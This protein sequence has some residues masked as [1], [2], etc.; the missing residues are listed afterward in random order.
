MEVD[1]KVDATE[2]EEVTEQEAKQELDRLLSDPQF[3]STDRNRN[4]LRFVASEMFEG[5][6]AAVKAYTIAVDVFGRPCSFDPTT[7]P[8]VRIE[9]TRLRA[10]LAQYY[11]A[12][13]EEGSVRIEL[14]RGRYIPV[15]TKA[16]PQTETLDEAELLDT[17]ET[18]SADS[19]WTS[20]T[21]NRRLILAGLAAAACGFLWYLSGTGPVFSDKPNVAIEMKLAG[22]KTDIEAGLIRDYLMTALSQYQTLKLAAGDKPSEA[23]GIRSAAGSLFGYESR[24]D[25]RYQVILKYHPGDHDRAVWWQVVNPATGEALRSGVERVDVDRR[26]G[27]D[28]RRE[29]ITDLANRFAGTR[30]VINSLELTRELASPTFGNGCVLRSAVA[31][32]QVDTSLLQEVQTCLVASLLNAPNDP[33]I[34]AELAIVNLELDAPEAPTELTAQALTLADKAVSLAP[35][36]DRAGY[37]QMLA[38]F[39]NDLREA[40]FV[41]GYRAMGLNPGNSLIPAELGAMLFAAGRW[42]EGAGMAIKA[43]MI[44]GVPPGDAEL[45][46]ALDA[47]RRGEFAEALL[48]VQ[49]MGRS[50]NYIANVLE[51]AA[52]GQMNNAAEID[53]AA[54]RLNA[55]RKHFP[56]S[57]RSDMAARHYSPEIVDQLGA[58]LTK[59]GFVL[60]APVADASN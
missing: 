55:K 24:V 13:A 23:G 38:Q 11:E 6:A 26:P 4:F 25:S 51:L 31:L 44:D 48:R 43:E 17:S 33:D 58:G 60:P 7:D 57:F 2:A 19:G 30:G 50:E 56:A 22:D 8:I 37:A 27:I 53:E 42:A 40:A 47:Y 18:G 54:K 32:E 1:V 29:L 36:S 28:V 49:Q 46:L 10:S 52:A 15:F 35:M 20:M 21:F 14:P 9:A 41:S 3:H 45:T 16:P 12:H 34:N 5:R 59:A 39:R